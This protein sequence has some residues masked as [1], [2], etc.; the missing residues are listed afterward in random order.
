MLENTN[1][2]YISYVVTRNGAHLVGAKGDFAMQPTSRIT[3]NN[4]AYGRSPTGFRRI[5]LEML[6]REVARLVGYDPRTLIM[7]PKKAGT[8][9]RG[10]RDLVPHNVAPQI[11][12]LQNQVQRSV[13]KG[14]VAAMVDYL[15]G[16]C[17]RDTFADWGAIEL[18]TTSEP[19]E[20]DAAVALDVGAD[21]FIAD[22]QHRYCALL[23]FCQSHPQYCDAFTQGITL[24]VMPEYRL[25]EWAGQKFHDHNYFSV[26]VRP[27]KALAVDSRDPLNALARSLDKHPVIRDAGGIA[28]ERDTLLAGDARLTTHS[29]IHRF[30]RG[31]IFGRPGLDGK[32]TA[33]D[34]RADIAD[35]STQ[36]LEQYLFALGKVLPWVQNEGQNRDEF[37]A[38]SSV[39]FAALAVIGHDLFQSGMTYEEIGGRIARLGKLDWRR[40]N[41]EWV[42]VMGSAKDGKVQPASSRPAIDGTIRYLREWLGLKPAN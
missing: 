19:M 6:P 42:G 17:E 2:D 25:I 32:G 23:D 3:V 14:R 13:D 12:A 31:F 30:V 9:A 4:P 18:I 5:H 34:S 40:T 11:I 37:L 7:K 41:L 27:G 29:V 10:T 36:H 39:A 38:R 20:L 24:S 22:G 28:Y 16:A 26:A 15:A 1:E 33:I 21:Y 35:V 8:G